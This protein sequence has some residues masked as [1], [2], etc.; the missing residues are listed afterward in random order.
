VIIGSGG[1]EVVA[2][3]YIDAPSWYI[4]YRTGRHMY[5]CRTCMK[6]LALILCNLLYDLLRFEW[7]YEVP[8][9]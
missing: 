4:L 9:I 8:I 5:L 7:L 2:L 6:A 1:L 3:A